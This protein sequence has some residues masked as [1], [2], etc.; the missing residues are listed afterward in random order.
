[1][2]R[3]RVIYSCSQRL[4]PLMGHLGTNGSHEGGIFCLELGPHFDLSY[5][6]F[7]QFWIGFIFTFCF[8]W[9]L[10]YLQKPSGKVSSSSELLNRCMVG[11]WNITQPSAPL[12]ILVANSDVTCV[13]C[14]H[15]H[16]VFG[17]M[18]D[19]SLSVWDLSDRTPDVRSG[20]VRLRPPSYNT[21]E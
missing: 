8:H 5:S 16:V 4:E 20:E 13:E 1:M 17:G 3:F 10:F 12:S 11:E 9:G 21:G 6:S 7:Q 14:E 15:P 2:F 19:G 18:R